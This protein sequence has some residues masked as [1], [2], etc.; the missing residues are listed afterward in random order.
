MRKHLST[1]TRHIQKIKTKEYLRSVDRV[2][3]LN[4]DRESSQGAMDRR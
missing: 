2:T 1:E 4:G 3:A